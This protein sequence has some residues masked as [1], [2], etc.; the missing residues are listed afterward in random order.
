M[1]IVYVAVSIA[2]CLAYF[3]GLDYVLMDAQG[4]DFFYMF[5]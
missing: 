3:I 1:T 2:V 5:R 4:L